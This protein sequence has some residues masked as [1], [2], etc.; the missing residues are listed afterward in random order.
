MT[1]FAVVGLLV[2]DGKVL[3]VSRKNNHQDLGLPGGKVDPGETAEEA[4]CR[5]VEEETGLHVLSLEHILDRMDEVPGLGPRPCRAFR[6]TAWT[7]HRE[8]T[9]AAWVGWVEPVKLLSDSCTFREYNRNLFR[10]VQL[11]ESM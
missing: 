5:E 11:M 9:E 6:I 8:P 3:A 7:K 1:P 2:Q 4:V 10:F